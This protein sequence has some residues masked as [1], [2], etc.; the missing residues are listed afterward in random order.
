MLVK[1]LKNRGLSECEAESFLLV[2]VYGLTPSDKRDIISEARKNKTNIDISIKNILVEKQYLYY[3]KLLEDYYDSLC[4]D[5]KLIYSKQ[6]LM[7]NM[8]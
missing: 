4:E 8:D 5:Y 2:E 3:V 7:L 6:L 1:L